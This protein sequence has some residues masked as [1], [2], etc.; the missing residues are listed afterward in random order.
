MRARVCDPRAPEYRDM[1]CA[2]LFIDQNLAF[3]GS[4]RRRDDA[5]AF[6]VFDDHRGLVVADFE[7]ALEIGRRGFAVG[8]D[9]RACMSNVRSDGGGAGISRCDEISGQTPT[10]SANA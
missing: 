1:V 3:A 5:L 8:D 10:R 9:D 4:I 7:L 6:E 2:P